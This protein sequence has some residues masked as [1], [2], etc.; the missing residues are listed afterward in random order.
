MGGGGGG[1]GGTE[2]PHITTCPYYNFMRHNSITIV[3]VYMSMLKQIKDHQTCKHYSSPITK[4]MVLY[5]CHTSE[6]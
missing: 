3:N 6:R 1:G 5:R 4:D 2:P